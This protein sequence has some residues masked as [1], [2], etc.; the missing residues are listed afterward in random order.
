MLISHGLR[1]AVG[2]GGPRFINVAGT[3]TDTD[4]MNLPSGIQAGD[5]LAMFISASTATGGTITTPSGW[6]QFLAQVTGQRTGAYYKVATG[7]EGATQTVAIGGSN[8]AACNVLL[9]RGYKSINLVGA[10]AASDASSPIT[11]SGITPTLPGLLL[12]FWAIRSRSS[13]PVTVTGGPSGMSLANIASGFVDDE[14]GMT[15]AVYYQDWAATATGTRE[16][17]TSGTIDTSRSLLVQIS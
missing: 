4:T 3:I 12:G 7:S 15:N 14:D 16:I 2:G 9:I 11:N 8:T 13:T 6:T 10:F 1:A 5:F 17:T